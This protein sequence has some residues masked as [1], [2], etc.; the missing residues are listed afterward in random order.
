MGSGWSLGGLELWVPRFALKSVKPCLRR[1]FRGPQ[2]LIA[3]RLV[4]PWDRGF[5]RIKTLSVLDQVL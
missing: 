4:D 3:L 2:S 5:A 1:M